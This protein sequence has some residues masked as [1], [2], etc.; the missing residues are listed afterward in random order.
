[1]MLVRAD[2]SAVLRRHASRRRYKHAQNRLTIWMKGAYN[3][4]E[5]RSRTEPEFVPVTSAGAPPF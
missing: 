5:R 2:V 3:G 1:M 4:S